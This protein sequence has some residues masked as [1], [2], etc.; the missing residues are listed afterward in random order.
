M[1]A[2]VL[3]TRLLTARSLR[4]LSR[5]PALLMFT[6]VQ[7]LVWLLLFGA[8]FQRISALPGFGADRYLDYLTPASSS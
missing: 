4:R 1:T 3:Q 7:P 5:Q 6:L 2:T 8:L